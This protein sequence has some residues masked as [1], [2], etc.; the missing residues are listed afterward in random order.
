[1]TDSTTPVEDLL[2]VCLVC[3]QG[4]PRSE[5]YEQKRAKDGRNP[6]CKV[7]ARRIAGVNYRKN[8]ERRREQ[9][10]AYHKLHKER[11]KRSTEDSRRLTLARN[12]KLTP[13]QY[14]QMLDSQGNACAICRQPEIRRNQDGAVKALA[15]D[16]DH[17]CC[18]GNKTCGRCIRGLLCHSCNLA[19]GKFRDDPSLL[20]AAAMYLEAGPSAAA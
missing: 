3:G 16:H 6:Y 9:N 4:K 19:L 18:P 12:F 20:L 2:K 10:R 13:E 5:F 8:I 15:V 14:Q 1:M 11:L 7:C 17:R